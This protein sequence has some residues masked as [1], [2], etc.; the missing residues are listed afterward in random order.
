MAYSSLE[1]Q[2]EYFM[3]DGVG[4]IA[5]IPYEHWLWA[6]KERKIVLADPVCALDKY[7]EMISAFIRK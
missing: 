4:Y 5:Y 7:S 6:W 1:P 3:V 2:M